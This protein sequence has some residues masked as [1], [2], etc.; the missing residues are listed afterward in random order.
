M[1]MCEMEP[2]EGKAQCQPRM[3]VTVLTSEYLLPS[4]LERQIDGHGGLDK[5]SMRAGDSDIGV[6]TIN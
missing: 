1:E 3:V 6:V 2:V 5:V 4:R